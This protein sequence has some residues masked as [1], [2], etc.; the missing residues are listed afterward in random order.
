MLLFPIWSSMILFYMVPYFFYRFW[1]EKNN[2]LHNNKF[3][4]LFNFL[5]LVTKDYDEHLHVT[6]EKQVGDVTS[7]GEH[8]VLQS[9][10]NLR[11]TSIT[12]LF[13]LM[14][15]GNSVEVCLAGV[16]DKYG[17]PVSAWF[18]SC[19]TSSPAQAEAKAIIVAA[20]I[21]REKNWPSIIVYSS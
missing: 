13:I 14:L 11:I 19:Y 8:N 1:N 4:Y 17:R 5:Q 10:K 12:L 3:T 15:P 7:E 20:Q 16:A 6:T 2:V 9:S 18:K 21:G